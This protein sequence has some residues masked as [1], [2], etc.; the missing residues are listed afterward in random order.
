MYSWLN[1]LHCEANT[2]LW[3]EF[4][5][6]FITKPTSISYIDSKCHIKKLKSSWTCLFGDIQTSFHV[7]GFYSLGADTHTHTHTHTLTNTH[8]D[9]PAKS[10]FINYKSGHPVW[11][12]KHLKKE[13]PAY[14]QQSARH[15]MAYFMQKTCLN[16][17]SVDN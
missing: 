14:S 9:F 1:A 12:T 7:N 6:H 16:T 15:L 4:T 13:W 3:Q 17:C 5:M 2:L 8:T 11:V 10:N